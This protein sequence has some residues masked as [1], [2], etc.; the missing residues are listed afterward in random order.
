MTKDL[1]L[2]FTRNPELGKVKT[3]LAAS[4]GDQAALDIYKFL[5]SHTAKIT[6]PLHVD[7]QVHYSVKVREGDLWDASVYDKKQQEG[8][9]LGQRM[10]FAFQQ[11]FEAGYQRIIIIGSDMYDLST[12]DLQQAFDQLKDRDYVIG[13]AEDGGYYLLGLKAVYP[14]IFQKKEWGTSTVLQDTLDDLKELDGFLLPQRN[15]VDLYEDIKNV[16]AFRG[17][18]P[19]E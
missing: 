15:D 19:E 6:A 5:L 17:F 7:K 12:L 10:A 3:R 18:L 4:I 14:A 1:L 11:G 13:P 2:I 9:D 16:D 8:A